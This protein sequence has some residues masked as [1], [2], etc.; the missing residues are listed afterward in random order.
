LGKLDKQKRQDSKE[1]ALGVPYGMTGYALAKTLDISIA[2]GEELVKNYLSSY[3]SLNKW[4]D[5]SKRQAQTKG[6][7]VS[8]LGRI[9]H[10]PKVKKLHKI[11]GEKL[12]D[13]KYRNFLKKRMDKKE[14]FMMY[15]DY[16]NGVNNSRNF[17]IQSMSAS[18]VN[19]AAIAINREF[20]KLEI[21]AWCCAQ[22]HDQL[23]FNIPDKDY[24][25]CSEIVERL[26]SST[27][28]LSVELKAPAKSSKNWRDG[29]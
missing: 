1:Y 14:I 24:K 27:T 16:K 15:M 7:V 13:Y 26:M 9:R 28:K 11:Y 20:I 12:L 21:N 17:Q 6:F 3:P 23:I 5:L 8:E 29:H 4:M 25:K 18:I 10:L 2:K 19:R 22:V